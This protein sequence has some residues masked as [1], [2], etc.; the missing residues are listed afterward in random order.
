M[1][2]SIFSYACWPSSLEKCL[3]RSSAH[4]SV[5]LFVGFL[6]LL[7][8]IF[9][10][11]GPCLL[12]HWQRFFSHSLCCLLF[13]FFIGFLCCAKPLSLIR[14]HWFICLYWHYSR[15]WIKQDVA[16]FMLKSILLMF[17]SRSFI[18]PGLFFR[19]LMHLSLFLYMMLDS[20]LL[21]FFYMWLFS[22]PNTIYWRGTI[23]FFHCLVCPPLSQIHWYFLNIWLLFA[24]T[25]FLLFILSFFVF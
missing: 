8:C 6:L 18:V 16:W 14:S 5:G 22:F 20:V 10:R 17:S 2:L 21:S 25:H 12:H 13:F 15:R 7:S 4:F 23:Y 24:L 11:L 1:I 9:W 3:F 19:S